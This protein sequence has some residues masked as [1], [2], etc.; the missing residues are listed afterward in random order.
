MKRNELLGSS[1]ILNSD[2][3]DVFQF[4]VVVGLFWS[5]CVKCDV[6]SQMKIK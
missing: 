1:S 6:K 2:Y 3:I 4:D 5:I